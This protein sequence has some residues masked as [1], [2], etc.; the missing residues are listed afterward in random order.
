MTAGAADER[1]IADA[2]DRVMN[3]LFG[4]GLTLASLVSYPD[5]DRHTA[6]RL[7]D[8][9][10]ELDAAVGELRMLALARAVA[11]RDARPLDDVIYAIKTVALGDAAL[12]SSATPTP[13]SDVSPEVGPYPRS[14]VRQRNRNIA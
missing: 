10:D 2:H 4:S 12:R 13:S 6:R 8:V 5:V 7:L 11:D 3:H 14:N 9:I 1:G